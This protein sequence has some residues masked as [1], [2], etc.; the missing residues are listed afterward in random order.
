MKIRI[1]T[2]KDAPQAIAKRWNLALH[3]CV[4][5]TP[6]ATVYKVDAPQGPAALKIY[7]E[8]GSAGEGAAVQFLRH[9]EP[10][11]GVKIYRSSAWRAAVLMEW[12]DGPALSALLVNG[13]EDT[14]TRHLAAVAGAV[15]RSRF[16]LHAQYRRVMPALKTNLANCRAHAVDHPEAENLHRAIALFDHLVATTTQERIIHGDLHFGNVVLTD[17]GPRLIDPKGLRADPAYEFGRVLIDPSHD[18]RSDALIQ[19]I[20][21]RAPIFADGIGVTPERPIQWLAVRLA[22]RVFSNSPKD[23][24]RQEFAPHL[25]AVLDLAER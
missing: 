8:I 23:A 3:G 4:A 7:N 2:S 5:K 21:R 18:V 9:L 10:G 17:D 24:S 14:A 1:K 15:A 6:R 11:A 22:Q 16:K 25:A 13:E 12:L 20:K 19:R